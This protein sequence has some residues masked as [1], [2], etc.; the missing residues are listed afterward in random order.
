MYP[1]SLMTPPPPPPYSSPHP[2]APARVPSPAPSV[3]SHSAS[4]ATPESAADAAWYPNF[5][6]S[7]HVTHEFQN[8]MHSSPYSSM[9]GMDKV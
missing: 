2:Y 9:S 5:G 1:P 8:L 7:S 6:A 4:I 3:Y